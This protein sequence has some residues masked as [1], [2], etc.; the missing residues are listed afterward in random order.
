[1]LALSFYDTYHM[2]MFIVSCWLTRH[3][4]ISN[5]ENVIF[6]RCWL[7]LLK[8]LTTV[9]WS[10]YFTWATMSFSFDDR[11]CTSVEPR[12]TC[13]N[14]NFE[15]GC[16]VS[17]YK[18]LSTHFPN[19]NTFVST[20]F[21]QRFITKYDPL[22]ILNRGHQVAGYTGIISYWSGGELKGRSSGLLWV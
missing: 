10:L 17:P 21:N 22:P 14:Q 8:M 6:L 5:N 16:Q 13:P 15:L 1:M 9:S 11:N 7:H 18:S 20:N 12:N 3:K 19:M 4:D 2:I